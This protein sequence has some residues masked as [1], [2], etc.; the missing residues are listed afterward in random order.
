MP[1][2]VHFQIVF[3]S[4]IVVSPSLL[5][6]SDTGYRTAVPPRLFC[7]HPD[8]FNTLSRSRENAS[9][10]YGKNKKQHRK[11]ISASSLSSR[12]IRGKNAVFLPVTSARGT[13]KERNRQGPL[14]MKRIVPILRLSSLG[15]R[16]GGI[17]PESLFRLGL[18]ILKPPF[19]GDGVGIVA[20]CPV[21]LDD[22]VL[23][24][25]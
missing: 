15:A 18:H 12:R 11:T 13:K 5:Q 3:G 23:R 20:G 1:H 10:Q 2:S 22:H 6:V 24:A 16:G 7:L 8:L 17:R 4:F 19:R 9:R 25:E 21:I 14:P